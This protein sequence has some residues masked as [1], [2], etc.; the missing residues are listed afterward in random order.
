M[1]PWERSVEKHG[2]EEARRLNSRNMLNNQNGS[3]NKGKNK[4]DIHKQ[5]ISEGVKLQWRNR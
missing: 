4:S 2:Y 1:S 5:N 3:G